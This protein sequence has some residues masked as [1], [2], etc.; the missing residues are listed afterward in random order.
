MCLT[1]PAKLM[2][3]AVGRGRLVSINKAEFFRTFLHFN[4]C[5]TAGRTNMKLNTIDPYSGVGVMMK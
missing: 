5:E 1:Q 4:S 3:S 2:G